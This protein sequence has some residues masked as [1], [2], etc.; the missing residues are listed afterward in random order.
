MMTFCG[1]TVSVC[2]YVLTIGEIVVRKKDKLA[3]ASGKV[4]LS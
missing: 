1:Y 2:I 3:T 4:E